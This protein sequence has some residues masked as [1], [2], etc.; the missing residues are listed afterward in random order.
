MSTRNASRAA[1]AP[2]RVRSLLPKRVVPAITIRRTTADDAAALARIM[3][4]PAV[5][6]GLM[7]MP[8]T[9]EEIWRARLVE[10][11]APGKVDLSIVAERGGEVVG[12]AGLHPVGA[13]ARRRHAAAIGIS[14][15]REAQGQGVGAALMQALCDYADRWMGFLRIELTVYVDNAAAVAIYRRFGFVIE[16]RHRGWAMRDGHLVDAFSMARIH[17]APPA[18]A[19]FAADPGRDPAAWL[20]P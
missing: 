18:I 14:V 4:D 8:Y 7:Q 12:S 13:A 6:P 15:A 16:G 9:N 5:Y 10:V 20:A 2:R 3:G 17:P 19:P 1:A 11:A